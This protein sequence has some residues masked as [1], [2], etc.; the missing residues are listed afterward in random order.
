MQNHAASSWRR[1]FTSMKNLA[2]TL[3]S[4]FR[5]LGRAGLRFGRSVW[6][7]IF[8]SRQNMVLPAAPASQP[9]HAELERKEEQLPQQVED[10]KTEQ[11]EISEEKD[12]APIEA[13][14]VQIEY[15]VITI[16]RD[17][18]L[19][20]TGRLL[21]SEIRSVATLPRKVVDAF[22]S[23]DN[24]KIPLTYWV[25]TVIARAHNHG[26]FAKKQLP[27]GD[28]DARNSAQQMAG[29]FLSS[30]TVV[31]L[32]LTYEK[33]A[34]IIANIFHHIGD[35]DYY[36]NLSD[37][38]SSLV[39]LQQANMPMMDEMLSSFI[40]NGDT[41][42]DASTDIAYGL[43]YLTALG[44]LT[45]ETIESMV[46]INSGHISFCSALH[47]LNQ[48]RLSLIK[49]VTAVRR[50]IGLGFDEDLIIDALLEGDENENKQ[51]LEELKKYNFSSLL[52]IVIIN[53]II[54]SFFSSAPIPIRPE[55]FRTRSIGSYKELYS[56]ESKA[57]SL[58]DT[59]Q[60]E[61]KELEHKIKLKHKAAIV[62]AYT[63]DPPTPT[64]VPAVLTYL[65]VNKILTCANIDTIEQAGKFAIQAASALLLLNHK[66]MLTNDTRAAIVRAARAGNNP[67]DAAKKIITQADELEK[68]GHSPVST[69]P[70][71][72]TD[73]C[74]SASTKTKNYSP[75][76]FARR[77]G[78]GG[79]VKQASNNRR[80]N[81]GL[82]LRTRGG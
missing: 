36:S 63:S 17:K 20:S 22:V 52:P 67:E 9:L 64:E 57:T 70:H 27:F 71:P 29:F 35:S 73:C 65:Q 47:A 16:M 55:S 28:P 49:N 72:A 21:P 3:S 38:V 58:A 40:Q 2:W 30:V 51:T 4:P 13:K 42:Y 43:K 31:R 1:F 19:Q 54:Y 50:S 74:L 82:I 34:S 26:K 68:K 75:S 61:E 66:K 39:S 48:E 62:R 25:T 8:P 14:S 53:N 23:L 80:S 59:K 44:I 10:K 33:L 32:P 7:F 5:M 41:V 12:Q 77:G 15:P 60:I 24:A 11:R 76:L 6:N 18:S 81:N 69:L 79:E 56:K 46:S 37:I 45:K 78:N